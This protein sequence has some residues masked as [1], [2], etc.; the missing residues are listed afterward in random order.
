ML[1]LNTTKPFYVDKI[2]KVV[3]MGNFKETGKEIEY[4]NDAFLSL[5]DNLKEPINEEKLIEKVSKETNVS[6][7][8]LKDVISYLLEEKLII[9][10]E[11]YEALCD[12]KYSR[13]DLFFS[14]FTNDFKQNKEL[15]A[16]K[17]IL[18]LGLGGV[19]ANVAFML[20]RAGFENFILVD[21]DIVECSNLIRQYPYSE[22][23]VGKNK[24]EVLASKL[25]GNIVIKNIMIDNK[26]KILQEVQE[27]DIVICTLDKPFRVIRRL[28]ND[29]CVSEN[30]P[31]IFAGFAEHVAMIGP[32]VIPH[33][34][35]CLKCIDKETTD[36]PL[37]NVK[38]VPSYG[39]MCA[40]IS[41][42]ITNEIV[43]YFNNYISYN[44]KGK[45][46]M[47]NFATYET[48]IINWSKNNTC[49]EC[50]KYDS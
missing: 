50:A 12:N 9:E 20:S 30:K 44:L 14:L 16:N 28:I 17:K 26:E 23:D 19:G 21:S 35:A 47:F 24:T 18:I 36:I 11:K 49:E 8:E 40:M 4:E 3:R 25:K 27:C 48:K 33:E 42:I 37:Q 41:S 46:M 34:T 5:I 22:N 1:I 45:T 43:K 10:N 6:K 29:I 2:N 15:F 38:I 32:F 39:P 7:S 13:Q 31:V